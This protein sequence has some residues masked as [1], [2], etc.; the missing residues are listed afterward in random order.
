V[1]RFSLQ[2]LSETFFILGRTERDMIKLCI[3]L[4]VKYPLFLLDFIETRIFEKYRN[5][6]FHKI[7][8]VGDESFRADRGTGD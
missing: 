7:R 3:G 2:L 4:H 1:F 8:L 6:K 5:I